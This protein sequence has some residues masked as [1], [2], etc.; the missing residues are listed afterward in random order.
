MRAAV[1]VARMG[2]RKGAYRDVMGKPEER[3]PLERSRRKLQYN[4][5]KNF[6]E[7]GCG[8]TDWIDVAQ[9]GTGGGFL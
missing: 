8:G 6:Q 3:R 4:I 7:V 2:E 9:V 5:K 1:Q